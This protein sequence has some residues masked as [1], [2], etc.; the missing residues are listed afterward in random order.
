MYACSGNKGSV[1]LS[2]V[3]QTPILQCLVYYQHAEVV[4]ACAVRVLH[5]SVFVLILCAG[6][7]GQHSHTV[8]REIVSTLYCYYYVS[9]YYYY[10]A[11][12]I[13]ELFHSRL[14]LLDEEKT[15]PG[16]GGLSV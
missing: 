10:Y 15:I 7:C 12:E 3:N 4:H 6:L 11:S 2:L 16:H 8:W 5:L 14:E 13:V 1:L 9:L